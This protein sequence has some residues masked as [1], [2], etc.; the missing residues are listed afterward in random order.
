MIESDNISIYCWMRCVLTTYS[1]FCCCFFFSFASSCFF[2][3]SEHQRIFGKMFE[4]HR[5]C[6][7]WVCW[8]TSFDICLSFGSG[9]G[10]YQ[11]LILHFFNEKYCSIT[12]SNDLFDMFTEPFTGIMWMQYSSYGFTRS[13]DI[14]ISTK[15]QEF[16]LC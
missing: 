13:S 7:T 2:F 9:T 14:F 6:V 3:F 11:W 10:E 16:Y 5:S 1:I 4:N 15:K 12:G 8:T